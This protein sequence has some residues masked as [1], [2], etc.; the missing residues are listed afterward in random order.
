MR[1]TALPDTL[2][3]AWKSSVP[4]A[5]G[6]NKREKHMKIGKKTGKEGKLGLSSPS[7][8]HPYH[9]TARPYQAGRGSSR[10]LPPAVLVKC[11][12]MADYLL[13]WLK[14]KEKMFF[15]HGLY[16]MCFNCNSFGKIYIFFALFVC[17]LHSASFYGY[18]FMYSL[19]IYFL[20][21]L[22]ELMDISSS[23]W[24]SW[25]DLVYIV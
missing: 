16:H 25:T 11:C 23:V 3:R 4:A 21:F 8:H 15:F 24:Q 19:I 18:P 12:P 5:K 9:L 2:V 6:R 1:N 7:V 20:Y 10:A 17:L 22:F 13:T 14:R